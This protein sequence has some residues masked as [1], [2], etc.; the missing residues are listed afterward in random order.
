MQNPSSPFTFRAV[1][2]AVRRPYSVRP[3]TAA[4]ATVLVLLV[5]MYM[6]IAALTPANRQH[7]IPE[8]ALD[9]AIPL[10]PLWV[11]VYGPTYLF[12]ILSPIF[13]LR[14]DKLIRRLLLAYLMVWLTS[15]FCF[16]TYP[17]VAPR[18]PTVS[19]GGFVIWGLQFLYSADPPYNCFPSLHVAHSVISALACH[20][21]HRGVGIAALICAALV[22][23][24]TLF[25]K[26]HY[27][28]D[29]IA[30]AALAVA[31]NAL[32]LRGYDRAR[33]PEEDRR[34]APILI[35]L[36][37]PIVGFVFGCYWLAYQL[38]LKA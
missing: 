10:A 33:V 16:V 8:L 5:P 37:I 7:H 3:V 19:A 24:S 28:L 32:F 13:I 25:I 14:E 17:T 35:L 2:A 15:Y 4:L 18:P 34:L 21:V 11:L 12:L 1:I 36:V 9:R 22:A 30:G 20:R 26:Q 23:I 27:V 29:I 6:F 38:G 31:A